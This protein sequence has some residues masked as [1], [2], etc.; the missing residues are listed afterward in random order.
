MKLTKIFE[1]DIYMLLCYINF[2][3]VLIFR[4]EVVLSFSHEKVK[5]H[6][7]TTDK[8]QLSPIKVGKLICIMKVNLKKN[9]L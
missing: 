4:Y 6:E 3:Y 8:I 9:L 5:S 2:L 7:K 1:A